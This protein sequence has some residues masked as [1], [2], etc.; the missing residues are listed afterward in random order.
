LTRPARG[1][2]VVLVSKGDPS[3]KHR[4]DVGAPDHG[5][6]STEAV[7]LGIQGVLALAIIA[8]AILVVFALTA[9]S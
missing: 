7:T 3:L 9:A 4:H 8:T 1:G 2:I 6:I 5:A